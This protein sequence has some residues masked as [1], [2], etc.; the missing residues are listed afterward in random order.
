MARFLDDAANAH[1]NGICTFMVMGMLLFSCAPDACTKKADAGEIIGGSAQV[2][3]G[4]ADT[5]HMERSKLSTPLTGAAE[6]ARAQLG[7]AERE[8]LESCVLATEADLEADACELPVD[9]PSDARF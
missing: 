5:S 9:E 7:A 1:N 4:V 6:I 3:E 8:L 2:S